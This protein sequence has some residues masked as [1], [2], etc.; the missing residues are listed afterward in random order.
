[1]RS[2]TPLLHRFHKRNP[3]GDYE[4]TEEEVLGANVSVHDME[5]KSYD[6]IHLEI[7]NL[8]EQ[9]R[10]LRSLK[11]GLSLIESN[12]TWALDYGCGTGNVTSKLL[13]FGFNVVAADI[14]EKML[15]TI[16][17]KF[18]QAFRSG[19]LMTYLVKDKSIDF[20]DG[21]FCFVAAYSVLHHLY[22]YMSAI[23]EMCRVLSDGG[24]LYVD[25]ELADSYWKLRYSPLYE[26]YAGISDV[27]NYAYVR[28][29]RRKTFPVKDYS[30]A[31]Y[32][33]RESTRIAWSTVK[34]F[35]IE[36]GFSVHENKY[37]LHRSFL[38]SPLYLLVSFGKDSVSFICV[39]M[40]LPK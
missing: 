9:R 38:P 10:L 20:P 7:F 11:R 21:F 27:A 26:F 33:T 15:E 14:S 6:D 2:R 16:R 13:A 23:K 12:S 39:K 18:P 31:D 32:R 3:D 19:R 5:A 24:V 1:M 8:V 28:Y 36:N 40:R 22:D 29:F 30:S 17:R 4:V 35:L 25:H 37:L 34:Q